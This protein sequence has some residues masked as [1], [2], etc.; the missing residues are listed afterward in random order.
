MW[1]EDDLKSVDR[2]K[3]PWLLVGVHRMFYCDS[4]DY[5][6]DDDGD[7]TMAVRMR[8]SLEDLFNEFKIDAMFFGH[9]HAYAR[10]CPTYKNQC[11][12][13]KGEQSTGALN[14]LNGNTTT[15]YYEPSAPIYFLIG[16]AGR[17]VGTA[18]FLEDPQPAIYANINLR[19]GYQR[20]RAN[21]T[22]LIAEAVESPSGY[23]MDAV[24]I[25]KNNE[26]APAPPSKHDLVQGAL[27]NLTRDA[28]TQPL[29]L[30]GAL[31]DLTSAIKG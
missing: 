31:S 8:A 20:L 18:D 15:V 9:M 6:S 5:R 29:Q 4:S 10:T 23:I 16:N 3:T 2:S 25:V 27:S 19:Y 28:F 26:T 24:T 21:A 22:H 11:K 1:I 7:Q 14:T 30:P 17:Q 12:P 13:S